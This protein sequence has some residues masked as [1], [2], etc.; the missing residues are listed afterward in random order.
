[1]PLTFISTGNNGSVTFGGLQI[2][3]TQPPI[4]PPAI[5]YTTGGLVLNLDAAEYGGSGNWLDLT[6]NGNNATPVQTPTYSVSQSGYFDL[7]GGLYSLSGTGQVDSFSI[8]DSS[9]LDTMN[10]MSIEMWINTDTVQGTTSPHL[11]FSKRETTSNGY[12]GFFTSASY[13]FRVGTT[14]ANQLVWSSPP[15]TSSWQQ[16]VITVGSGS[17]GNVYRNGSLVQT[18]SYTGSFGNIGTTANLLLGDVNPPSTGVYGYDGKMSVF[19]MY[20]RVLSASE[21]LQNY[22]A[23]KDRYFT[24]PNI[25]TNNLMLHLDAGDP[26]SYGGS[27]T[28]WYD[29][30]GNNRNA[31]LVNTPTYDNVTAGGLFSFDDVSFE[32]ATI[33]NIGDLST[34]TIETWCRVHKSLTGKVTSVITNQYNLSDRLNFSI[35]TNRSPTSYNMSFGYFKNPPGW[36]NVN[37]FAPSLNT[38]YHLLGTY[39]G[40]SL[41]FYVN[42]TLGTQV[43]A[44]ATPQSGGE[45]RIARRWDESATNSAN[46][47]DGDI[48][49]VRIYDTALTSTQVTQNYDS[50]KSRFG[51]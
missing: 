30:T 49:V 46:F 19:R 42:G 43:S 48:S 27:G 22:D 45:I 28:T 4:I 17:G 32:H 51:L 5:T 12:V 16:L 21:V 20:N 2:I 44:S 38:W 36:I 47:F 6:A 34:F 10:S 35:G 14:S 40:T 8:T 9:T 26:D 7:N 3:S 18:S 1:M 50:E 24:T 29:L 41:K 25:V 11:L 39:D 13:T 37:G 15:V 33:P 31:T 23:V